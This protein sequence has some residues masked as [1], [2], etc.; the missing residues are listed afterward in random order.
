M[1][2]PLPPAASV[3]ATK[4]VFVQLFAYPFRIFF[5]SATLLALLAIPAWMAMLLGRWQ[6][7]TLLAAAHWHQHE[8]LFG[9][10]HAAI[11]GF[12]LTAVCVWTNTERSHGPR[13]ALLWGVWLAGRAAMLVGADWPGWLAHALDLSFLPL[14]MLDAGSRIWQA[15]QRRHLVILIVLGALWLMELGFH[16]QPSGPGARGAMLMAMALMLVIGGRITPAFTANWLR[17]TGADATAVRTLPWLEAI[18]PVSMLLLLTLLLASAPAWLLAPVAAAAAL[19]TGARLLLWQG[20]L[21]RRE[22]LLWILHL[23]LAWIPLALLLLAASA[24][25]WVVP[26]AWLHA[27]GTGAMGALILGVM[28]RVALGHTGRPLILPPGM[29]WA[30]VAVL[31]AGL[32]RVATALQ[33]LPWRTGLEISTVLWVAAYGLFGVRY[34]RMLATP[35]PDGKPG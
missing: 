24:L 9:F 32:V 5:A 19:A 23:A 35:R 7:P 4:P 1:N 18:V 26:S 28:S 8:M 6:A 30:F 27:A 29:T 14:V 11:A 21:A 17:S 15:R 10:L 34:W 2:D 13:L 12:L 33:W 22:P 16:V 25:G 31:L 20:W 3:R